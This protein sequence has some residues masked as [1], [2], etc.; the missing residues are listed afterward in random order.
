MTSQPTH[1]DLI[2]LGTGSGNS[3][4]TPDFD[5]A[6][7]AIVERGVFGGT[8]LNRG[9]IPSK[10]FV[11]AADMVEMARHS[12]ELGVDL[13]VD[14]VRWGDIVERV[15]GRI[16]PIAA[17]GEAYRHGLDNVTVYHGSGRFTGPRE[18]IVDGNDGASHRITGDNVVIAT[19][20]KPSI[21]DIAGLAH[22]GYHTSDTIMRL[23]ELPRRLAVLGGGYIATELAHVFE[24]LGSE[25]T[26]LV[27]GPRLLR[28]E[29]EEVSMRFTEVFS[30]RCDV[31]LGC[32]VDSVHRDESGELCIE[33]SVG[34][35]QFDLRCDEILVATGREPT[36]E[37]LDLH[38]AGVATH[39]GYVITDE[40]MR[41]NVDGVWALG[42]I[43]NPDQLK[44]TANAEARV[45]AHNIAHP[46]DLRVVDL[47]PTPHAVFSHPQ[48][49]AVGA[50]EQ[51]LR[52]EGIPYLVGRRDH[53]GTAYG[54]AMEDRTGFAK[55][56]VDPETRL[57]L[58]AHIIGPQA[59][60]LIHQLIQ[61]MKFGQTVD[62]LA[63]GFLYIHP[64]LSE[65]VENAL[66]AVDDN[67]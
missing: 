12:S 48:V 29:D 42:D 34:G 45:V 43:T 21:P 8:C 13:R 61:G 52:G 64:A 36:S 1:Y 32:S 19:G 6:R 18:L 62:E 63:R 15:F 35:E 24:A 65:L 39:D 55:V 27:R 44:H 7:V 9:C 46:D 38:L 11:Y 3:I 28:F 2:I 14:G 59:A 37:E 25:V 56:L 10:M 20:A 51:E 30:E 66:L 41:T 31:R 67:D 49:A 33:A 5:D 58:G 16:D 22:A 53:G 4:I 40:Y 60:T 57:L 23:P 26:L 47:W 54:W 17:G 50:T